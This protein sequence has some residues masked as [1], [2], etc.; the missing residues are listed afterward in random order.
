[1]SSQRARRFLLI[2]FALSLAIHLMLAVGIRWPFTMPRDEVQVV[3][4]EHAPRVVQVSKMPTPIPH[5]PA[6]HRSAAPSP[7]PSAPSKP[8]RGTHG[9]RPSSG[10]GGTGPIASPLPRATTTPSGTACVKADVAAA[11]VATPPPAEIPPAVRANATDGTTRVQVHL[12]EH[13]GVIGATVVQTSGNGSLDLV[14]LTMAK[15]AQ[16]APA[17]KACKAVAGEYT[18]SARFIP[19]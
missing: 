17:L 18:F 15:N 14:A 6:P 5:T 1:M 9:A 4:V 13:G 8:V 19:W 3:S 2:A 16:Y 12:D 7:A 10:A 11:L